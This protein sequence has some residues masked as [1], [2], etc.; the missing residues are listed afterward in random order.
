MTGLTTPHGDRGSG[1]DY[2]ST[3]RRRTSLPLMG[4]GDQNSTPDGTMLRI[5]SLPLMGIGDDA[6][7]LPRILAHQ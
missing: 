4:I 6:E 3:E 1:T 5:D 2:V 7:Q